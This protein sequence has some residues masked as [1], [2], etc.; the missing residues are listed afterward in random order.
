MSWRHK[1]IRVKLTQE[2][3]RRACVTFTQRSGR[4]HTGYLC[5]IHKKTWD[6]STQKKRQKGVVVHTK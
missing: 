4:R 5:D 1:D 6:S 3:W 2:K